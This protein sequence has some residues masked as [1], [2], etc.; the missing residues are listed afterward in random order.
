MESSPARL[1]VATLGPPRWS[2]LVWGTITLPPRWATPLRPLSATTRRPAVAAPLLRLAEVDRHFI[3]PLASGAA[4]SC[5]SSRSKA[6]PADRYRPTGIS[7]ERD[8]QRLK[9]LDPL[10][11]CGHRPELPIPRSRRVSAAWFHAGAWKPCLFRADQAAKPPYP[12]F[13]AAR[14]HDEAAMPLRSLSAAIARL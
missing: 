4:L 10:K 6:A 13:R 1:F 7:P 9:A 3:D 5:V 11:A 14:A 12:E 8:S 2:A